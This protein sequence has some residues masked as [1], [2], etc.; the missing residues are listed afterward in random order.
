MHTINF[1]IIATN[2]YL[3]L[4]IRLAKKL[5][6]FYSGRSNLEIHIVSNYNIYDYINPYIENVKI[7]H[8]YQEHSSWRDATNSRYNTIKSFK[9][10]PQDYVYYIDADTNLTKSFNDESFVGEVVA[11]EHFDNRG[12]LKI[13]KAYDRNS[14]SKAYISKDTHLPQTYF[15][16]AFWGGRFEYI[17]LMAAI[18]KK[19]QDFD[20]EIQYEPSVNDESYLNK[21][22]H[23]YPPSKIIEIWQFPFAVSCKGGIAH[24]RTVS[25]EYEYLN[26]LA[27]LRDSTIEILGGRPLAIKT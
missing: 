11:T 5:P 16:G 15:H 13:N 9:F 14:L 19:W 22:F 20:Q 2:R 7:N 23:I 27:R 24:G 25:V 12:R 4:G 8:I 6:I 1:F 26:E 21:F 3:P 10:D 18:C 17:K